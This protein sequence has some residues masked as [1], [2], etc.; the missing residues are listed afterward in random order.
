MALAQLAGEPLI[1][2][3]IPPS[4]D[5]FTGLLKAAGITP[6]LAF[7]SP[8]LELVRGLVGRGL[9]YS[10]LVTR[11]AGDRTYDGLALAARPIADRVAGSDV[12]LACLAGVRPSRAATAFGGDCQAW[13]AERRR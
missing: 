13:F 3:D 12:A 4:R 7:A 8:S 6:R 10:L 11:P 5:Y 9:G 2:L 1:L